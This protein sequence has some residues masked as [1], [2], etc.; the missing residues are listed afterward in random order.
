MGKPIG[1]K[2]LHPPPFMVHADQQVGPQTF[3]LP[4]ERAEL[5][6]IDPV[7]GKQNQPADQRMRQ[8]PAVVVGERGAG[9][10]DQKWGVLGHGNLGC[11]QFILLF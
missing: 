8:S 11:A 3:D 4:G 9:D 2:A 10:V 1:A 7:A 6:P 5:G